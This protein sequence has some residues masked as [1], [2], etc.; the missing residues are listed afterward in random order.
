MS[1]G[2]IG[3]NGVEE[4]FEEITFG[5]GN[6]FDVV[7]ALP[8]TDSEIINEA[9]SSGVSIVK[10]GILMLIIQKQEAYIDKLLGF[11]FAGIGVMLTGLKNKIGKRLRRMRGVRA[12][13][14][15]SFFGNTQLDAVN[16]CRL[17]ADLVG[18]KIGSKTAVN[19][20]LD[21]INSVSSQHQALISQ[22]EHK[23]NLAKGKSDNYAQSL[24]FKLFTQG[25]TKKDRKI[26]GQILGKDNVS[27]VSIEDLN[28]VS[29]FMYVKDNNGNLTGLSDEFMAL[30]NGLGYLNKGAN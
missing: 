9:M 19:S 17:G 30:L 3:K 29:S 28:K 8:D 27:N 13:F 26:I 1:L 22:D 21:K 18:A 10:M 24:I 4:F 16:T 2:N 7:G 14:L 12:R 20:S 23:L 25:F 15:M 5:V 6:D 11:L